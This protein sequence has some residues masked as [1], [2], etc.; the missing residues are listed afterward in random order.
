MAQNSSGQLLL[1]TSQASMKSSI[2]NSPFSRIPGYSQNAVVKLIV[3]F[4]SAYVIYNLTYVIMLMLHY[5]TSSFTATFTNNL[6]LPPVREYPGKFWTLLTYG[7]F[8]NSFMSMFSNMIWLYCFG[9]LVQMMIG[10]RQVIPVFLYS[11]ATGGVFCLLS[12]FIPGPLFAAYPFMGPIAGLAGLAAA[13]L[14]ISPGYKFYLTDSFAIPLWVIAGIFTFLML[15][16]TGAQLSLVMMLI[17]GG[18]SG[19]YYVRLLRN[20]NKPGD[21]MY[22]L[23]GRMERSVTPDD[24]TTWQKHNKRRNDLL[25]RMY[26]PKHGVTQKKID[27]IL[28]KIHQKGYNSLSQ[29]EKNTLLQASKENNN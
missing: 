23:Y 10:Y 8:H 20:G 7:W 26:E 29:E 12:Q 18:V 16:S 2:S 17:G 4:L 24:H 25:S 28:D 21:W 13:A 15:L 5:P 9:S 3:Y 6:A 11:M 27:D 19:F 14:T 22:N 1:I